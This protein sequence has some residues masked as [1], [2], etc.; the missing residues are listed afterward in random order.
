MVHLMFVDDILLMSKADLPEW[1]AILEVLQ[2]FC[3]VTGLSINPLKSSIH[4]WGL[5][6]AELVL[7]K[8]SI[9]FSFSDLKDGF[10]Y[11]GYRLKPG[12]ASSADWCW[13]VALFERKIGLWCNKWLSLGGRYVLVKSVLEGLAVYW[14]TLERIPNNILVLLRRLSYNFL[15]NDLAGKRRFHLCDWQTLAKPRKS[16]GWG[17][18]NLSSFNSALLACSF[19]RALSHDSIW[20]RVI[21]D[22]YLGSLPLLQWLRKP[23]MIEKG[24]TLLEGTI[25]CLAGDLTLA[26]LEAR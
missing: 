21:I 13:L 7:F 18:K 2:L 1:L 25:I 5:T 10:S 20:N 23:S 11:L 17:F 12:V 26:S 15:W 22:K 4:Y 9:P 16:G 19:W 8:N 24:F 6:E 3:T 14:M